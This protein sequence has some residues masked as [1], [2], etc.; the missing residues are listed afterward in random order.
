MVKGV[1][2]GGVV[3]GVVECAEVFGALTRYAPSPQMDLATLEDTHN[4]K[5]YIFPNSCPDFGVRMGEPL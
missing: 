4:Q 3:L 5:I 2:C 1:A